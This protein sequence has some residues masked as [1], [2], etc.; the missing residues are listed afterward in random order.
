LDVRVLG[1][2]AR[3]RLAER[4]GDRAVQVRLPPGLVAERVEN[5]ERGVAELEGLPGDSAG[6]SRSQRLGLGQEGGELVFLA[7]LGLQDNE[8][9]SVDA[10]ERSFRWVRDQR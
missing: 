4:G 10:H 5:T 9:S 2:Q 6:L 3:A 1:Q 7:R 8:Q